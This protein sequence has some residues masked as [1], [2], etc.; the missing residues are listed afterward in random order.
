MRVLIPRAGVAVGTRVTLD[1]NEV[2]HLRVRRARDQEAVELLDGAGISGR[3]RLIRSASDWLVE[4][5]SLEHEPAPAELTLAVAAGDRDR[6][7]W[8]AEKSVELGATTLVPLLTAHTA[9]VATRLKENHLPRLRRS[10]LEALKQCGSAWAPT[11]E[12]LVLLRSFLQQKRPGMG[13][14]ADRAGETAPFQLDS[15]PLTI[16]VGP[17]G[18]LTEQERAEVIDAGYCPVT[19]GPHTLRFETAAVAALAAAGQ[20]RLRGGSHG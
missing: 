10:M 1:D 12:D 3:G 16:V 15:S 4:I 18:G 19:L 6:F 8:V 14:L 7:I 11:L 2:H 17:E 5:E 9:A 13:W 20:A